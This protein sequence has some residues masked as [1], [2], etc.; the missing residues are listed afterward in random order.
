MQHKPSL[1]SVQERLTAFKRNLAHMPPTRALM[2][3]K[4]FRKMGRPA[5][6]DE[7]HVNTLCVLSVKKQCSTYGVVKRKLTGRLNEMGHQGKISRGTIWRYQQKMLA[8]LSPTGDTPTVSVMP[9]KRKTSLAAEFV[10]A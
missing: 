2:K 3:V 7:K 5:I 6:L 8:L 1:T 9:A 4:P 10:L